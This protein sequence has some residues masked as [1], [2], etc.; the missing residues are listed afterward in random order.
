MPRRR[1]RAENARIKIEQ[2]EEVIES[3]DDGA[4]NNDS[5][6]SDWTRS[7]ELEIIQFA[8]KEI[9]EKDPTSS[10]TCGRSILLLDFSKVL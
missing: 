1:T 3:E 4:E 8:Q 2:E 9:H 6:N 7:E 5:E 10:I